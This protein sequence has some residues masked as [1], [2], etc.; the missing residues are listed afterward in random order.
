MFHNSGIIKKYFKG[1]TEVQADRF[2]RLGPLYSEWNNKIT[3]ISRKDI[4]SLYEKHILHSLA[5]A[6]VIRFM[7]GS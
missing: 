3:L 5:I 1:L 2:N 4:D 6:K 7:P